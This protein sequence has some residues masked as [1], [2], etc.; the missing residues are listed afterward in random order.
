LT[1]H[2]EV[3]KRREQISLCLSKSVTS[4]KGISEQ[5]KI[6]MKTVE[7]DLYWMRKHSS[8]W[9]SNHTLDGYVF[10]TQQ[11]IEQLKDIE[12]ELQSLRSKEKNLDKKLKIIGELTQVINMRWVIQGDGPTFMHL[13]S[14]KFGR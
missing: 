10:E 6:E 11:T 1:N 5:T 14:K 2:N 9:L 4:P 7:N 12:F 8:K 13:Q 3:K